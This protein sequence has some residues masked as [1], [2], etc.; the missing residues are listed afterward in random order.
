MQE[1]QNHMEKFRNYILISILVNGPIWS[2]EGAA[3][4]QG[5]DGGFYQASV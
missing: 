4:G 5:E 2:N 1:C 3:S